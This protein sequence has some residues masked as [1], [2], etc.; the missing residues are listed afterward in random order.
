MTRIVAVD[1]DGT[2]VDTDGEWLPDARNA[3]RAIRRMGHEVVVHS[4]RA[5]WDGGR[6]QIRA[7][8]ETAMFK[9]VRIEP[10]LDAFRYVDN[11]AIPYA[12]D[13]Y[14]VLRQLRAAA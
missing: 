13:W 11:L 6:E 7:K 4:S 8:L 5:N 14:R 10:K 3:L 2:L 1:Y 9:D 12:G